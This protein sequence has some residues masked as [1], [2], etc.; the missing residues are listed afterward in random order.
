ME[1][2]TAVATVVAPLVFAM[3]TLTAAF[4]VIVS[5]FMVRSTE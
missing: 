5:I 3:F 4:A 1:A 2:A